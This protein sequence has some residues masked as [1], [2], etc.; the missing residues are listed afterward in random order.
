MSAKGKQYRYIARVGK[1][2]GRYGQT[3]TVLKWRRTKVLVQ[4]P[5]GWTAICPGR[6][7]RKLKH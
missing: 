5:D 3:V 4:F 6:C 1:A 2:T 7:L